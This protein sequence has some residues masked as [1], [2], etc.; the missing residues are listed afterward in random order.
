MSAPWA[1]LCLAAAQMSSAAVFTC[2]QQ[3]H[4]I[5]KDMQGNCPDPVPATLSN[6]A[7]T[8]PLAAPEH[9]QC[10]ILVEDRFLQFNLLREPVWVDN[11]LV[12][13]IWKPLVG[14]DMINMFGADTSSVY[15]TNV[16]HQSDLGP[17]ARSRAMD[18][19]QYASLYY[20]GVHT[21]RC[22]VSTRH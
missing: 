14:R 10:V 5:R 13:L 16:T 3:E 8:P 4:H 12:R 7:T 18:P 17:K 2:L 11:L 19:W 21:A 9:N 20:A 15:F 6:E 22:L 1:V